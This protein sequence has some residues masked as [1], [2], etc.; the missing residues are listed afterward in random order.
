MLLRFLVELGDG[1][2]VQPSDFRDHE[3]SV[4]DHFQL[5]EL[6]RAGKGAEAGELLT[7][8]IVHTYERGA[9]DDAEA[10]GETGS[11]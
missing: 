11:R 10:P 7:R 3:Q 6:L 1:L 5:V 9:S 2:D 8:H 4:S